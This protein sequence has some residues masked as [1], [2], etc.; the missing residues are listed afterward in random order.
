MTPAAG[1]PVV[2]VELTHTCKPLL[3]D[4]LTGSSQMYR[5]SYHRPRKSESIELLP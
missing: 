5:V 1:E 2:V 3:F 4:L